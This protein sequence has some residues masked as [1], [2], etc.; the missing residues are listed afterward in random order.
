LSGVELVALKE[1]K[2]KENKR[3]EREEPPGGRRPEKDFIDELLEIFCEE[4]ERERGK[5]F[6]LIAKAKERNAMGK[7]L[8]F[9]KSEREEN[10]TREETLKVFRMMFQWAVGVK[11]KWH[12]EKMSPT[13]LMTN[14]NELRTLHGKRNGYGSTVSESELHQLIAKHGGT[15]EAGRAN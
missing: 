8:A 6:A 5:P 3:K 14:Y 4:Y 9:F 2:V 11:E 13:H 12:F 15:A 10:P 7:L 1:S